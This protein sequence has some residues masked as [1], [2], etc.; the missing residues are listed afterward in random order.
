MTPHDDLPPELVVEVR[1]L[2]REFLDWRA[3]LRILID[4]VMCFTIG[5]VGAAGWIAGYCYFYPSPELATATLHDWLALEPF[6]LCFGT[7]VAAL[8]YPPAAAG[9]VLGIWLAGFDYVVA[10]LP[11]AYWLESARLVA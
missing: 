9:I 7:L 11:S 2:W 3:W 5:I 4:F 10:H 8:A 1:P 6:V